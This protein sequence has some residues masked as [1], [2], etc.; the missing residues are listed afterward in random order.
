MT[1]TQSGPPTELLQGID[2]IKYVKSSF[3]SL[4]GQFFQP[5]TNN[6]TLTTVTNSQAIMQR[7]Q[8]IVTQPDILF[9]ATDQATGPGSPNPHPE[10]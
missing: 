8:R 7:F 3:D 6:Y 2:K 9:T 5:I 1:C 10:P 4:L